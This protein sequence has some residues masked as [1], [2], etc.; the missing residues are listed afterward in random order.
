MEKR[1]ILNYNGDE[2]GELSVYDFSEISNEDP[3]T[4]DIDNP[5]LKIRLNDCP[6]CGYECL[7]ESDSSIRWY[8]YCSFCYTK[9]PQSYNWYKAAKMW[10]D[11]SLKTVLECTNRDLEELFKLGLK[12]R[13][14]FNPDQLEKAGIK[15]ESEETK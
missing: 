5:Y 9:G 15:L 1:K 4:I 12:V 13:G 6:F 10:N 3:K 7:L 8:G 2:V 11:K 14:R